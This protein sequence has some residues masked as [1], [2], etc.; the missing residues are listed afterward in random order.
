MPVRRPEKLKLA[1]LFGISMATAVAILESGLRS[2]TPFPIHG[3]MANRVPHPI[4]G[5]TLDPSDAEV[6]AAGFRN[7]MHVGSYEIVVIGVTDHSTPT[8][9]AKLPSSSSDESS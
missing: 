9:A 3:E 1:L 8:S 6:D 4:L 5:Y 2:F 7:P